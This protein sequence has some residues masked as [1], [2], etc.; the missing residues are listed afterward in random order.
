[1]FIKGG[2][3]LIRDLYPPGC[4]FLS[5]IDV[6]FHEH[7]LQNAFGLLK[8]EGYNIIDDN[9]IHAHHFPA[10]EHP[11]Y[12]SALELHRAPY[13]TTPMSGYVLPGIWKNSETLQYLHEKVIVPSVTDHAWI[14]MRTDPISRPLL[15]RLCDVIELALLKTNGTAI[16]FDCLCQRAQ[17]ENLPNIASGMS[18]SCS[19][20]GGME[21]FAPMV[22]ERL[23]RWELLSPRS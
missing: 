17:E 23:K 1:M 18:Y 12:A 5:D 11:L 22:H 3:C 20:Y 14:L 16:D 13:P 9:I 7:H 2:A 4:R 15:P 6:L 21:P 19:I 8:S 10:L